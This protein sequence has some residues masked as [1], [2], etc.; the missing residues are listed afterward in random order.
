MHFEQHLL[1][2]YNMACTMRPVFE[3]RSGI[4]VLSQF[5]ERETTRGFQL[6]LCSLVT[7]WRQCE[8]LIF[9]FMH[10]LIIHL[11]QSSF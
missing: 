11:I 6:V 9:K 3:K 8:L 5:T 4:S 1:G 7:V 2:A 10:S